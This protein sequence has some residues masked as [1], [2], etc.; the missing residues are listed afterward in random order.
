MTVSISLASEHE[1]C[2]ATAHINIFT[3]N[4]KTTNNLLCKVKRV[5]ALG[6]SGSVKKWNIIKSCPYSAYN[7]IGYTLE[8]VFVVSLTVRHMISRQKST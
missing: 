7:F 5:L 1:Y 2:T 6:N 4:E 8:V 3:V